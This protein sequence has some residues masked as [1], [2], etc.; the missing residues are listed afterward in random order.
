MKKVRLW[1]KNKGGSIERWFLYSRVE[2]GMVADSVGPEEYMDG[3]MVMWGPAGPK[4][5]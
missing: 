4:T 2:V 3:G 5:K 1:L